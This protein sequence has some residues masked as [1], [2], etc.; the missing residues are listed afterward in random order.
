MSTYVN[1][2]T[3]VV[4]AVTILCIAML[5]LLGFGFGNETRLS[6]LLGMTFL[7]SDV[8]LGTW[9]IFMMIVP[10]GVGIPYLAVRFVL[11]SRFQEFGFGLGDAKQGAIWLLV[12]TPVYVLLPLGSAYVGTE[13]YYTMLVNPDFLKPLYVAI[14]CVSYGAFVFGF[15]FLFR[16]FVLF[17]LNSGMGD[18]IRSKVIAAVASGALA[19]LFLIGLPWVFP[20]SAFLSTVPAAFLNFRLRS[21]VYFAFI[22]WNIGV[23]SDIWEIIKMNIAGGMW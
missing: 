6:E 14:H 21:F 5:W 12:L 22:H 2:T 11:R 8:Y 10:I 15:E 23:W 17:G 13:H 4:L 1:K 19:A 3:I 16:G 9:F 20:V 18:T 7:G